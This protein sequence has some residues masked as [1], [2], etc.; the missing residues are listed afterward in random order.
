[1]FGEGCGRWCG[2]G[3]CAAKQFRTASPGMLSI[4]AMLVAMG[5]IAAI[6]AFTLFF[7]KRRLLNSPGAARHLLGDTSAAAT[8]QP[9]SVLL[10]GPSG[11]GKSTLYRAALALAG[12]LP[13]GDNG[14][15]RPT[16]GLVV[17]PLLLPANLM[18]AAQEE[19]HAGVDGSTTSGNASGQWQRRQVV[20]CDAGGG[21]QE[22]RQWVDLV[23]A[24]ARI[25][26]LIFVCDARDDSEETRELFRQLANAKWAQRA[27]V[28]LALTKLDLLLEER[29][30]S[31]AR[32]TCAARE[33]EYRAACPHPLI[34]HVLNCRDPA[35]A[36]R[37]LVEAVGS[38][39]GFS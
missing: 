24:P 6:G 31:E 16:R 34:T 39:E 20:L 14:P 32:A 30:N 2:G 11:G 7:R 3:G 9:P 17:Q 15:P 5:C 19:P 37:L 27:T 12:E 33:A 36:A 10:L 1:M 18:A 21:R 26:S 35:A 22:R 28:V 25:G 23:R 13:R 38:L 29:G 4:A 8:E